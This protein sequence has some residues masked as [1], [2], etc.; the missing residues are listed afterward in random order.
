MPNYYC[1]AF[2]PLNIHWFCPVLQYIMRII[3][4]FKACS[5]TIIQNA[6]S[7]YNNVYSLVQSTLTFIK[8][9]AF[10]LGLYWTLKSRLRLDFNILVNVF[11]ST[12]NLSLPWLPVLWGTRRDYS[13]SSLILTD[14]F[15]VMES[16]RGKQCFATHVRGTYFEKSKDVDTLIEDTEVL[17]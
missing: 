12:I 2:L 3:F 10:G 13:I 1:L 15:Q 8:T 11:A 16:K 4:V 9:S 5:C 6:W 17:T 7:P 14:N